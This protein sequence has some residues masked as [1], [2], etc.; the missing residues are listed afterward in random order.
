[1]QP[2]T[3]GVVPPAV[4]RDQ[5]PALPMAA[6]AGADH[7][8]SLCDCR[9]MC[10]RDDD[11][12]HNNNNN[13]INNNFLT[14]MLSVWRGVTRVA[15]HR[16]WG[17]DHPAI[18]MNRRIIS[19]ISSLFLRTLS[20]PSVSGPL[21]VRISV[22]RLKRNKVPSDRPPL[23]QRPASTRDL[24]RCLRPPMLHFNARCHA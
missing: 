20:P 2:G 5:F 9:Y 3:F 24:H 13:N 6:A 14:C 17:S 8:R 22:R 18:L 16:R 10:G 11:I 19:W 15:L 4:G 12:D 23:A 1:M 21:M 7:Q